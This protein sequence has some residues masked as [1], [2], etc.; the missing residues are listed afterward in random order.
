MSAGIVMLLLSCAAAYVYLFYL[1]PKEDTEAATESGGFRP[2]RAFVAPTPKAVATG[3]V[4]EDARPG[5]FLQ[6]QDVGPRM[7]QI[8]A[9]ITHRHRS[10]MGV[11]RKTVLEGDTGT[12]PCWMT[13]FPQ[14]P[15]QIWITLELISAESLPI[16]KAQLQALTVD[17]DCTVQWEGVTYTFNGKEVRLFCPDGNELEAEEKTRWFFQNR[18]AALEFLRNSKG[19]YKGVFWAAVPRQQISLLKGS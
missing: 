7:L 13:T 18:D 10:K 16:S 14:T 5:D 3:D 4:M 17:T 1:K 9:Q 2:A 12:G 15:H 6:L 8:S 19:E 11:S